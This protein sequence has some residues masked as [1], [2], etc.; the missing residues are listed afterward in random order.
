MKYKV[1][2]KVRIVKKK[3]GIG[4]NS[5]GYM[6]KWL[7]KVMTIRDIDDTSYRMFEDDGELYG[8]GWYWFEY[9]IEGLAEEPKEPE[10]WTDS[11]IQQARLLTTNLLTEI[12]YNGG[13]IC[14]S[15]YD[16]YD[17]KH[18]DCA[19]YE[20]SFDTNNVVEGTS[21][22]CNSDV[23]NEWIGKCVAACNALRHPIPDFIMNK[24]K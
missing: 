11:E 23:Y 10:D 20:N 4:W 8:S 2:D 18:I 24:N 6:D 12:I 16:D 7:G 17:G 19:I 9:M 3:T 15:D 21:T 5:Y 1:G 14:F 22:C 13:D